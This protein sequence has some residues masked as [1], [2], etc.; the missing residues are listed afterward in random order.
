MKSCTDCCCTGFRLAYHPE[1]V[2]GGIA[3]DCETCEGKGWLNDDGTPLSD[4]PQ[5]TEV[6]VWTIVEG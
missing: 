4:I 3:L 6:V 2:C 5:G 1:V